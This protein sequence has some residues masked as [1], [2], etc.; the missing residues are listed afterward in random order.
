MLIHDAYVGFCV[1]RSDKWISANFHREIAK[2]FT[3]VISMVREIW[4][5]VALNN[6]FKKQNES[7]ENNFV[8]NFPY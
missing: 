3:S 5:Y 4:F 8:F 6:Q 7:K 2:I 1:C